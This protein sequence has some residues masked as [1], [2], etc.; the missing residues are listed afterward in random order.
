MPIKIEEPTQQQINELRN[1]FIKKYETNPPIV[2]FH[3]VDINRILKEDIWCRKFLEMYD[4]DMNLAFDKLWFT[5]TWRQEFGANDLNESDLRMDY[6]NDGFIFCHNHDIDGKPLLIFQTKNHIRGSKNMD[7]VVKILVYYIERLHRQTNMDKI[8]IF[9]DMNGCGL[10]NMD[11]EFIKCIIE[12]FKQYYP[13][14]LNYILVYEMAWILNAAFKIVKGLMP[15]KAVAILKMINKKSIS[16][17]I[18]KN[19]CLVSWGGNDNYEFTFEPEK[20]QTTPTPPSIAETN[21]AVHFANGSSIRVPAE[22]A[23]M[24][25]VPERYTPEELQSDDMLRIVP[26]DYI[27]FPRGDPSESLLQLNNTSKQPVTFKIQTTSPEK[28]R[29]RP[30][31]GLINPGETTTVNILLKAEHSLS[32]NARDKFLIMCLP[33]R[34]ISNAQVGEF[35]KKQNNNGP[36]VEQ[37]RLC[38]IYKD[39]PLPTPS[40]QP[41]TTATQKGAGEASPRSAPASSTS[42]LERQLRFTQ[43]LQV[44]T[45]IFLLML[46]GAVIYLLML[47][48]C[49]D[50]GC[51]SRDV[52][53]DTSEGAPCGKAKPATAT[54][55]HQWQQNLDSLTRRCNEEEKNRFDN[56][57]SSADNDDGNNCFGDC[58]KGGVLGGGYLL[59]LIAF[60]RKLARCILTVS[61]LCCIVF[62]T[63]YFCSMSREQV[64]SPNALVTTQSATEFGYYAVT[65]YNWDTN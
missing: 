40:S 8:T 11:L 24:T 15:E 34:E 30:R 45:L 57:D 42:A 13:S 48:L 60:A 17:Y 21:G 50:A 31:C 59:G 6:L 41:M 20:K 23:Q 62:L 54:N 4:L 33:A 65:P 64:Y 22:F 9:F 27:Q 39:A 10:S 49:G 3:P 18:D 12:T 5:C 61:I 14:A 46:S 47:Q 16:T 26:N 35:W 43:V 37:H 1:L 63:F 7:D 28:F 52:A 53:S 2:A 25:D 36:N 55:C 32:D 51:F 38:C 58:K 29:V 56:S 19:N 44:I